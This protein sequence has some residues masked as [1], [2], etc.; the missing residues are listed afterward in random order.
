MSSRK[1]RTLAHD[2]RTG[3]KRFARSRGSTERQYEDALHAL[4]AAKAAMK[5]RQK[6]TL[7]KLRFLEEKAT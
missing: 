5:E 2:M 4:E 6:V 7:P 3:A 1:P